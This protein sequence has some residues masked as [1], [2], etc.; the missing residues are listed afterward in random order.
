MNE[1]DLC[2]FINHKDSFI[3]EQCGFDLDLSINNDSSGLPIITI[4]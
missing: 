2:S 4:K 3:C 1:C